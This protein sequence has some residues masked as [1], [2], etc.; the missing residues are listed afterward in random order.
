LNPKGS[1]HPTKRKEPQG[2]NP[3][4]K[5]KRQKKEQKKKK[6]FS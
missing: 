4:T 3:K 5:D 1:A 2:Q 6:V